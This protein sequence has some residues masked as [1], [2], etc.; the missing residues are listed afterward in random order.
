M[1]CSSLAAC[2]SGDEALNLSLFEGVYQLQS[3]SGQDFVRPDLND[4]RFL[5]IRADPLSAA[6]YVLV[7]DMPARESCYSNNAG[8]TTENPAVDENVLKT[9]SGDVSVIAT[10]NGTN[11]GVVITFE[12]GGIRQQATYAFVR[13]S[14]SAAS[15]SPLCS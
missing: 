4:N 3:L 13:S 5:N 11:L 14:R 9:S 12:E 2:D 10:A 7:D 8:F 1:P 6:G 15:F